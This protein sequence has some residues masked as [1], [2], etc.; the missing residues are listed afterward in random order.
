MG[1]KIFVSYK[2]HDSDVRYPH[3]GKNGIYSNYYG[4]FNKAT[5]RDYVDYFESKI[6][7]VSDHI[8]KGEDDGED[9]SNLSDERI[10]QLLADRIYD[11]SV[12][13]VF[14]SPNMKEKYKPEREQWIPW[15]ISYSLKETTR[16]DKNGN[17]VTSRTNA[18][19]AVIIPDKRGSYCY[20]YKGQYGFY[21][22]LDG[23]VCF[24]IIANNTNNMTTTSD[25]FFRTIRG[26]EGQ[27]GYFIVVEWDKFISNYNKYINLAIENRDKIDYFNV[28]KVS[29]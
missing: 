12:T 10:K 26:Q 23:N 8:Y 2:Y 5:V 1:N 3:W 13:V 25:Y 6:D 22:Q 9:L 4:F 15:E 16:K 20:A 21:K 28:Q 29:W 27:L 7:K 14:I 19:V 18:V 11:S 24:N 17:Q